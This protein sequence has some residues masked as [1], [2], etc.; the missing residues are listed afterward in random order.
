[1]HVP[2][3]FT[4]E[5]MRRSLEVYIHTYFVDNEEISVN[6]DTEREKIRDSIRICCESM[7]EEFIKRGIMESNGITYQEGISLTEQLLQNDLN[8]MNSIVSIHSVFSREK[9]EPTL[10][11]RE[12]QMYLSSIHI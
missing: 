4:F 1:M 9:F 8:Q 6:N 2:T 7:G 10:Y 5:C 12:R 11:K 3:T